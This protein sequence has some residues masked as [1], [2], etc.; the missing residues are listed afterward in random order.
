MLTSPTHVPAAFAL[1][2]KDISAS[3]APLGR[4]ILRASGAGRGCRAADT[5]PR[6]KSRR[7]SPRTCAAG[8]GSSESTCDS[9]KNAPCACSS[10]IAVATVYPRPALLG[11]QLIRL[12]PADHARARI[13]SYRLER[14]RPSIACT[15]SAI[16]TAT[17]SRASRSRPASAIDRRS[18]IAGRAR[19]RHPAGQPVRLLRRRSRAST[20]P[21]ALPRRARRRARARSSTPAIRRIGSAGARPSCSTSCRR[22]GDTIGAA[23]RD[24]PRSSASGSRT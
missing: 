5:S 11:P 19:G 13:E 23:R 15:G 2:P 1:F 8:S 14:S 22:R 17:T 4:A 10:S 3:A 16:R 6:S 7:C 21:F 24:Q 9:G 18:T 20:L 12:R